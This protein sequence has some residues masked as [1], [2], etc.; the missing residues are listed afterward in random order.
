MG[1]S[2]LKAMAN[3]MKA[4]GLQKLRWY[5]QMCE[6]QCRDENGFRCH[7]SSES[8]QRQMA[9]FGQAPDRAVERFSGEFLEAFLA[10]LRH[11]HRGSRVAATVVYNQLVADRRHVHMNSTRW[12]TL[13][14]FV[15]F[16]G[17]QGLATVEHTPKGWFIAYVDRGSEQAAKAGLKRKRVQS[18]ELVI[19]RQIERAQKKS[20]AE[21]NGAD[22]GD[23]GKIED[24]Y[25]GPG[26]ADQ[27]EFNK[28]TGKVAIALR[29]AAPATPEVKPEMKFGL[30]E[31]EEEVIN[32]KGKDA[33]KSTGTRRSA[34]DDL[35]EEEEKAK[36]RSNRKDHWLCPGIVVKVMSKSLAEKGHHYYK[37][38]GLVKRVIDRYVGEIEML[39]SKHVVRVDQD[40]LETVVPRIGGLVRIVNGAYRGSNAR[41][42]SVDMERFSAKLR[43]EKGLYDGRILEAV[44]YEDICKVAD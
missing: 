22:N 6:K 4:K 26:D 2:E 23:L 29:R 42:L 17:R 33:G 10:L 18:E 21:A 11:G 24:A 39:E 35:M 9:V 37:H 8:H 1:K 25:S 36:D 14:E 7:C 31:E 40:E 13:T 34:I 3:R 20:M 15:Q 12:A 30:D 19:A 5:C 16:L 38:K 44:E 32:N 43:I 27:E 28:A 41:L